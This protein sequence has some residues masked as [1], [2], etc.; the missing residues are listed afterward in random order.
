MTA[1]EAR[2][3]SDKWLDSGELG[4]S[5]IDGLIMDAAS[6]GRTSIQRSLLK[7]DSRLRDRAAKRVKEIY[8]K[9]GF[10]VVRAKYNGDLREPQGY[11]SITISW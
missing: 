4:E 2:K 10:I 5:V 6:S 7:I 9:K 1:E 11:D 3:L 8:E